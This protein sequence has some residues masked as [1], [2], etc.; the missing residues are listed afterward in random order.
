MGCDLV[1]SFVSFSDT[2]SFLTILRIHFSFQLIFNFRLVEIIVG[3]ISN[4]RCLARIVWL[5]KG[6]IN[7]PTHN[8][9]CLF[10]FGGL[11]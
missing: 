3:I 8:I 6:R 5:T 2:L 4:L 9:I 10:F 11:K 7:V 1:K